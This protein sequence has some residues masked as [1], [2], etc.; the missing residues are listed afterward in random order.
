MTASPGVGAVMKTGH[1]NFTKQLLDSVISAE[2]PGFLLRMKG[3]RAR[4]SRDL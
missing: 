4:I 2:T 3:S 1:G